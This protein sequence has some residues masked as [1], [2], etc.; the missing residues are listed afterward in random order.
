[1]K[2]GEV[3]K[4]LYDVGPFTLVKMPLPDEVATIKYVFSESS[5]SNKK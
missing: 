4:I 3:S 1:M 2:S 5:N